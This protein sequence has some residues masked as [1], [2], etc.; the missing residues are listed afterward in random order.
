MNEYDFYS[1]LK[2]S[3]FSAM[4]VFLF[5]CI[6]T[7]FF[8]QAGWSVPQVTSSG[9]LSESV[10]IQ[11]STVLTSRALN[12]NNRHVYNMLQSLHLLL[13]H[14]ESQ[15][16]LLL[17]VFSHLC[18]L[19]ADQLFT[20]LHQKCFVLCVLLHFCH[21]NSKN[22]YIILFMRILSPNMWQEWVNIG[23]HQS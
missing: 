20:E 8:V 3:A 6:E 22:K 14:L 12:R 15:K 19:C 21:L 17:L 2:F 11:D 4:F 16:Q 10:S 13:P 9:L 18:S 1:L 23:V 5:F 7:F